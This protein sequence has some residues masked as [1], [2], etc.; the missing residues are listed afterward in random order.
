MSN[1]V[2]LC[3]T[4]SG[5]STKQL[6]SVSPRRGSGDEERRVDCAGENWDMLVY[7]GYRVE[8]WTVLL[9]VP[10]SMVGIFILMSMVSSR[11]ILT[12]L[13]PYVD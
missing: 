6:V 7:Q 4:V 1:C 2:Y 5:R 11:H 3:L 13:V 9:W 8:K 12:A 10:F